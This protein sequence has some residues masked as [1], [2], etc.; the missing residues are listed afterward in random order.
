MA[1]IKIPILDKSLYATRDRYA[2]VHEL[3]SAFSR[4]VIKRFT[5]KF[6]CCRTLTLY[7]RHYLP[8][9]RVKQPST[10]K[11]SYK[12][13]DLGEQD[14]V[15][16]NETLI[17]GSRARSAQHALGDDALINYRHYSEAIRTLFE[18]WLG[19]DSLRKRFIRQIWAKCLQYI[20]E[21]TTYCIVSRW[22]V[23]EIRKKKLYRVIH[24]ILP[25]KH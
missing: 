10:I 17:T 21:G 18:G 13:Y 19:R 3:F 4:Q 5:L 9:F 23:Y 2:G 20:K 7:L 24:E 14:C 16:Q 12:D 1:A 15:C 25:F 6:L 8:P 11:L 22:C